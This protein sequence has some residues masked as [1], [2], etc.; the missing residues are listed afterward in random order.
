MAT[1]LFW[2]SSES[3]SPSGVRISSTTFGTGPPASGAA[4]AGAA[5]AAT[6]ARRP[7]WNALTAAILVLAD[8][9][10]GG[11]SRGGG[12]K[13]ARV[14]LFLRPGV[15][16]ASVAGVSSAGAPPGAVGTP[17][18]EEEEE[19]LQPPHLEHAFFCGKGA[20]C[21]GGS[22]FTTGAVKPSPRA[23]EGSAVRPRSR[24]LMP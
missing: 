9:Q 20:A 11:M 3:P 7:P 5:G 22:S 16:S 13:L 21:C 1:T 14:A 15:S 18:E 17:S 8:T 24:Q 10:P 12:E 19:V 6:L 23:S 4:S 2:L